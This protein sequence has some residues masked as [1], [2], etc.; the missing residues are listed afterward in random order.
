MSY[1]AVS[2]QVDNYCRIRQRLE[3]E[4]ISHGQHPKIDS[5]VELLRLMIEVMSNFGVDANF[6]RYVQ[7]VVETSTDDN[8][9]LLLRCS[10]TKYSYQVVIN[11]DG[12]TRFGVLKISKDHKCSSY[13]SISEDVLYTLL[14]KCEKAIFTFVKL[15]TSS[16]KA[17]EKEH[18]GCDICK[19]K[20]NLMRVF[21]PE[22]KD[23]SVAVTGSLQDTVTSDGKC[24]N[25]ESS[26]PLCKG[27]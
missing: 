23:K 10:L 22:E 5:I 8:S 19:N 4:S 1:S 3:T 14:Q 26:G 21:R 9:A 15:H 20:E 11:A 24:R 7:E 13:L 6:R 12:E 25:S 27:T 2:N 16:E 17:K 18:Y